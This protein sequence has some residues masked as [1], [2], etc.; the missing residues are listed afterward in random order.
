MFLPKLTV[1]VSL[2]EI[3]LVQAVLLRSVGMSFTCCPATSEQLIRA[4]QLANIT[5]IGQK[6]DCFFIFDKMLVFF[7]KPPK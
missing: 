7:I 1:T 3:C 2:S 6:E 5:T 4:R